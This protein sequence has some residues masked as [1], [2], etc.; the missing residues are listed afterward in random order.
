MTFARLH[1]RPLLWLTLFAIAMAYA[2]AAVVVYL[3]GIYHPDD[4]LTIFPLAVLANRDLVIEAAREFAT[5]AMI[6]SV[7]FLTAADGARILAAFAYTFGVWDIFYYVWLKVMIGWPVR[8]LEW[9]L[10][11]LIPWP[12]LGPWLAAALVSLLLVSWGAWAL[13]RPTPAGF[14]RGAA[15]VLGAGAL[16]VLICFLWPAV[17]LLG[18]GEAAW[19]GFEPRE[20]HWGLFFAGYLLMGCGCG[21]VLRADRHGS[22]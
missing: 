16:L 3:R 13:R 11:F 10:L 22:V 8:W 17:P 19:R 15:A 4:P 9:D 2:E 21:M 1:E 5:L 7:S 14:A 6:L 12:W 18:S 20:F